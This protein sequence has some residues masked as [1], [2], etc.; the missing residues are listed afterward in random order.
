MEKLAISSITNIYYCHLSRTLLNT[1]ETKSEHEH[2]YNLHLKHYS[3]ASWW[4]TCI[5]NVRMTCLG[6]YMKRTAYDC[7]HIN[8]NSDNNATENLLCVRAI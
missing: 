2:Q 3:D 8:G 4:I 5:H 7:H 6:P 1:A